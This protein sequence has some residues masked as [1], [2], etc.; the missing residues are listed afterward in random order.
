M[1]SKVWWYTIWPRKLGSRMAPMPIRKKGPQKIVMNCTH[2]P[3]GRESKKLLTTMKEKTPNVCQS[4]SLHKN[5]QIIHPQLQA[6]ATPNVHFFF[7]DSRHMQRMCQKNVQ[8]SICTWNGPS[9]AQRFSG[10]Y[11]KIEFFDTSI[12]LHNAVWCGAD[13]ALTICSSNSKHESRQTPSLAMGPPSQNPWHLG[14]PLING[15]E[16]G[17]SRRICTIA[18]DSCDTTANAGPP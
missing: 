5:E 15:N 14:F 1:T 18:L 4:G 3:Y 9:V 10:N 11:P 2:H 8:T 7:A 13:M 17:V 6:L 16:G 12:Y